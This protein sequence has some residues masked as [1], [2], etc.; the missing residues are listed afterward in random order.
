M[1]NSQGMDL[2]EKARKYSAAPELDAS[3]ARNGTS[4]Q[5]RSTLTDK[6]LRPNE[7]GT[8]S[9]P[10][11]ASVRW[12]ARGG[13]AVADQGLLAGTN[14]VVSILLARWLTPTLYGA[15]SV[16]LAI[17]W[18]LRSLYDALVNVPMMV[19]GAGRYRESFRSYVGALFK[20][21]LRLMLPLT[22]LLL[23]TA[24]VVRFAVSSA[25][26]GALIGLAVAAPPLLL[27]WSAR[28]AFYVEL[29]VG[30]SLVG[31]AVFC[32]VSIGSMVLLHAWEYLTPFTAFAALGFGAALGFLF[33]IRRVRPDWSGVGFAFRQITQDHLNYGRWALGDSAVG[34]AALNA[35]YLILPLWQGLEGSAGLRAVMN[36]TL[37]GTHTFMALGAVLLPTLVR[38]RRANGVQS[39]K[40]HGRRWLVIFT[41]FGI[42]Y[43]AALWALRND[44]F[45]LFYG[46][47]Y[48]EHAGS[49]IL[50][51]LV[52]L[53][54]GFVV[55][56]GAELQALERPDLVF[57]SQVGAALTAL[58]VGLGLATVRGVDGAVTGLLLSYA[59]GG[60]L[61]GWFSWR[62]TRDRAASPLRSE[63]NS[64]D[65]SMA[66]VG[67]ERTWITSRDHERSQTTHMLTYLYDAL[68][69]LQ[70][71][72]V[73]RL[74]DIGCGFGGLT[75]VV[76]SRLGVTEAHGIDIDSVALEEARE[77]GV[78]THHVDI[79]N[80][81]LPFADH[82]LDMVMS[83]GV[84][85]YLTDF[86]PILHEI[87]R[88]L[89]PGGYALISLPNLAGWQN[90][91]SLLLG[92]QLRDVE[93]SREKVVGVHPWYR[94]DDSPVG[95]IHTVTARAFCDL[96][97][98]HGFR[99][100]RV[101]PGVP[102][103][104]PRSFLL[105]LVDSLLSRR[106]TLARRFFYLGERK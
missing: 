91:L 2:G 15:V 25:V 105:G 73:N 13:L 100:V 71:K 69:P 68:Q 27:L 84:L 23:L 59:V 47:R 19:F 41:L 52:P 14:F 62:V 103:A 102:G 10:W 21:Q 98:H 16:A 11:H 74:L 34:W 24:L 18:L 93:V 53:A 49:L 90:R 60:V 31:G 57:W 80:G 46:G 54:A 4:N 92:Y 81:Q 61:R 72:T 96:M 106:V 17:S 22:L 58:T 70:G 87:H 30:A 82:Y 7:A 6:S 85:D 44:L 64:E 9:A 42:A 67:S 20:M 40:N 88:V 51:G 3:D 32:A 99:Q 36:F 83:F 94:G 97:D 75:R 95:H 5:P 55:V 33:T 1:S 43:L 28:S 86:S 50:V 12:A 8:T 48:G 66:V 26:G 29:R 63:T 78:T 89:K 101:T 104:R 76:G 56:L 38:E 37:P 77:K 65:T 39:M 45:K 79:Q 35:Y